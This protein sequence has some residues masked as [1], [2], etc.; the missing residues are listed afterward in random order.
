M[1]LP[2]ALDTLTAAVD[3]DA[4]NAQ[5]GFRVTGSL[6]GPTK[7]AL[8]SGRHA[9]TV[10]EP[11]ALGGADAGASPVEHALIALASCHAI[12]YRVWATKLGLELDDVE[13]RAEGELDLRGFLGLDT[14]VRAGFTDVRIVVTPKGP[15]PA[16]RYREL[17]E[18]VDQHCPVLDLFSNATPVERE[19]AI[20][21]EP[22]GAS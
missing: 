1:S 15:E 9:V 16:E 12:A 10:D 6:T 19:L 17:A 2:A 14:S 20:A 11:P 8:R 3:A 7:V 5:V 18:A 13:V 22:A 21:A 4:A